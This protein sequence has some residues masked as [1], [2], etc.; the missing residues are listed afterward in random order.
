MSQ[1]NRTFTRREL[2]QTAG[3]AAAIV[4]SS[5][6]VELALGEN[7]AVSAQAALSAAAG[8]DRIVMRHGRT[9][10]NA[11][12]GYGEKPR[13][14]RS[15]AGAAPEAAPPPPGP[16]PT[17]TWRQVSGPGTVTFADPKEAVTTATFS[18]PGE[19]WLR[20]E[21]VEADDGFDGLCCFTFAMVKVTVK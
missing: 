10:L 21:P 12:A 6:L 1:D 3:K 17:V 5:P 7:G 18:A 20:A 9:Y 4:V 16:P 11:W 13:R 14:Q 8:P 19:Y 2:L 15:R